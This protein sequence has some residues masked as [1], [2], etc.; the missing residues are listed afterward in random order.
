MAPTRGPFLP[1]V[2]AIVEWF[3]L[4]LP[5][6]EEIRERVRDIGVRGLVMD[7]SER[8][9]APYGPARARIA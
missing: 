9:S 5:Q 2:C 7:F 3:P 1:R 4:I 6:A 8:Y